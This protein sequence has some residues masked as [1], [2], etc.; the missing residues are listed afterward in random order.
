M[1]FFF[2][3]KQALHNFISDLWMNVNDWKF[4]FAWN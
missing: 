3:K 1:G 4:L 2:A